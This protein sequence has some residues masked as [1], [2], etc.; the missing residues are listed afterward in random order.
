M[1]RRA[2]AVSVAIFVLL[3]AGSFT[4][5]GAA[6]QP[7][8]T[9]EDP[10]YS[11]VAEDEV[12][13][14]GTTY[15]FTAVDAD[16]A[17]AEW[18]NQS[19]QYTEEWS[20]DDTV[21]YKGDNYTVS[22]PNQSETSYF[23]LREV[24]TVD[25]PTVEQNGTTYVV[26]EEDGEKTLVPRDEYLPEQTVYRFQT[27]DQIDRPDNDNA[28]TIASVSE[29]T[30]TIQWF[31]PNTFEV[32]FSEGENTT[33]G[34]TNYLTHVETDGGQ[35]VLELT[36]DYEDYRSDVDAQNY[37]HERMNGLWGIVILSGL[38]ASFLVMFAFLP[39]RY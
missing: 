21:V 32:S 11:I 4:L 16:S 29:S 10:E 24:Q 15:H 37:F 18:T 1:Q 8:L 12:S 35:N 19:A 22:V 33:L 17:T 25:E 31:A 26:L 5:M 23:E 38:A 2:A 28:T 13:I 14:E 36:T 30:V 39:S 7:D 9:L 3:A 34:D 6:Q 20:V 27:G